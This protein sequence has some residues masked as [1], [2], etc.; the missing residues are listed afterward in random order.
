MKV[1]IVL[2]HGHEVTVDLIDGIGKW[3]KRPVVVRAGQLAEE[4]DIV[5]ME[6][7]MRGNVGDWLII[8]VHGEMYPCKPEIFVETYEPVKE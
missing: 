7:T 6:G 3:R 1:G 4:V 5:T 8:G 2:N